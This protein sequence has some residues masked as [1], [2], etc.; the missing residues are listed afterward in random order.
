MDDGERTTTEVTVAERSTEVVDEDRSR[1]EI[2][3]QYEAS[4]SDIGEERIASVA[5]S[6]ARVET[7]VEFGD[8]STRDRA[9]LVTREG[10]T[11]SS[12]SELPGALM[13]HRDRVT[14]TSPA[15]ES[16][17]QADVPNGR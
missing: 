5:G 10:V 12:F 2:V 13:T 9:W 1:Q 4:G 11:G 3:D 14:Q 7:T 17:S 6:N 15:P 16:G 8:G